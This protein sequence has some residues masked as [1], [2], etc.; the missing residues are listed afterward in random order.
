M[1]VSVFC[2]CKSNQNPVLGYT[3][4][5]WQTYDYFATVTSLVVYDNFTDSKRLDAFNNAKE[6]IDQLLN[7][8]NKAVSLSVADS[9]VTKFNN[10]TVNQSISISKITADIVKI[11]KKVYTDTG[12]SYDP[13]VSQLV[14]LWGLTPRFNDYNYVPKYPYDRDY[15]NGILP[16]PDKKYIDA[17]LQL[18][19][20]DKIELTENNGEYTLTKLTQPIVIDGVSYDATFDLGGMAKGYAVDKVKEILNKYEFHYGYFSCGGS[21]MYTLKSSFPAAVNDNSYEYNLGVLKPRPGNID[22]ETNFIKV[23]IK[24]STLST[25]GDYMHAYSINGI[26][27]SHI[28]DPKT[29]YPMNTSEDINTNQ[30]G[31]ATIT[32][33]GGS[34]AYDDGITTAL[35]LLDYQS[36]IDYINTNLKS[37]KVVMV[38]YNNKFNTYEIVTNLTDKNYFITDDA[39]V[40]ASEI[41]EKGNIIYKGTLMK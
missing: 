33:V 9:D 16:L 11:A 15:V 34:G 2:G 3:A 19:G 41:D 8:V 14:D 1:L 38:L 18:V 5:V 25:S 20:F 12:T 4:Q 36:A 32:V 21:S 39:Y 31:I 27:Y 22:Q 26:K 23:K 35:C 7:A 17:F 13:T 24:D 10:L 28:I 37:Y 29:G 30:K 40:I 6:E